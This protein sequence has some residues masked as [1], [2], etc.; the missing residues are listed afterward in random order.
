LLSIFGD[1]PE[2][3]AAPVPAPDLAPA[4]VEEPAVPAEEPTAPAVDHTAAQEAL[5]SIFGDTPE[6]EAAPV[7]APDLAPAPVEEPAV[8]AVDHTAAQEA[9]LSIFGDTPDTQSTMPVAEIQHRREEQLV[10]E[11]ESDMP[12]APRPVTE[13]H[14]ER[15]E[16]PRTAGSDL[17]VRP[18]PVIAEGET[19]ARPDRSEYAKPSISLDGTFVVP[20]PDMP[21]IQ[22]RRTEGAPLGSSADVSAVDAAWEKLM[23]GVTDDQ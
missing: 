11:G 4:P 7:P 22:I 8:P 23:N 2:P 10:F 18:M 9:L 12:V 3:E 1:T 16:A 21:D 20:L 5:L 13:N 17:Y 14:Y 15:P 19:I 6:S